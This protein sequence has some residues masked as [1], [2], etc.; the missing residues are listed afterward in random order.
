MQNTAI[1]TKCED[2]FGISLYDL[3]E[4]PDFATLAQIIYIR[5]LDADP[6]QCRRQQAL[7][8]LTKAIENF[9]QNQNIE[10]TENTKLLDL[11]TPDFWLKQWGTLQRKTSAL[12]WPDFS[13]PLWMTAALIFISALGA[14]ELSRYYQ[15][16]TQ[17]LIFSFIIIFAPLLFLTTKFK[18]NL[19]H[20]IK[21]IA[22]FLPYAETSP[23]IAWTLPQVISNLK[24]L[25]AL[26]QI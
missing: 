17:G 23:R 11:A 15:N 22:D 10:I 18:T 7:Y 21:T 20:Q 5:I 13:R 4:V 1:L 25:S 14:Y 2:C 24:Q 16:H 9:N 26:N 3:E 12:N 8:H 6:Q 19:P